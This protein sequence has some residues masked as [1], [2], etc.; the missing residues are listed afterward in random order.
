[1]KPIWKLFTGYL[2]IILLL[3]LSSGET[4]SQIVV[5]HYNADW[6]AANKVEWIKKLSDCDITMVDIVK[7]PKLQAKHE[8][9]VV[10]TIIIF[11]DGE[12]IKKVRKQKKVKL[13]DF[14]LID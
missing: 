3:I 2:L 14:A 9:V 10:P 6:N 8:I 7:N 13:N 11:K 4:F 5:T 12:E 1:M